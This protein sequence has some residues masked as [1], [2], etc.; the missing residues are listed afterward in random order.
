MGNFGDTNN[1]LADWKTRCPRCRAKWPNDDFLA[2]DGGAGAIA[3]GYRSLIE[4]VCSVKSDETGYDACRDCTIVLVSPGYSPSATDPE[5]WEKHLVFW[6]N[7]VSLLPKEG[8]I[9]IG[10]REVF[11]QEGTG[12]RWLEAYHERLKAKGRSVPAF[13][14]FV[15]GADLYSASSFNYPY[16]AVAA[17]N[18]LFL[19]AETIFNFSGA[20]FQEPLQMLNGEFAWNARA[21]GHRIPQTHREALARWR[22]LMDNRG[23]P[24]EIAGS[25]GLLAEACA[26]LYGRNAGAA[27]LRYFNHFKPQP[28]MEGELLVPLMPAKLY[29]TPILWRIL[30]MDR[31]W[32]SMPA[33]RDSQRWMD[34]LRLSPAGWQER[35]MRLWQLYGEVN[36]GAAQIVD[37]TLQSS[38]LRADAREDVVYLKKCL[39]VAR[40]FSLLL[41]SYHQ[42]LSKLASNDARSTQVSVKETRERVSSLSGYLQKEFSFD[43][44]DPL[45][46]DQASWLEALLYLRN[47][48]VDVAHR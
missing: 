15:G 4:A 47:Q 6:S 14:F 43:T 20:V 22:E 40:Q 2:A 7:V 3:H 16:S 37:T 13:L 26:K 31:D 29:P 12:K 24:E 21:P 45:G 11:P 5:S 46:G 23:I 19:G 33:D 27:M 39:A 42:T 41:A 1:Q 30:Q 25:G 38:D 28:R 34:K 35:W 8:N 10:F 48:L 32:A 44:V 17:L 36:G 18:G 9:E